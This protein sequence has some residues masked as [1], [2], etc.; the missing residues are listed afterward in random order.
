MQH[1]VR[2]SSEKHSPFSISTYGPRGLP[3]SLKP[4]RYE[5]STLSINDLDT[6]RVLTVSN[7]FRWLRCNTLRN[8]RYAFEAALRENPFQIYPFVKSRFGGRPPVCISHDR[9]REDRDK[10]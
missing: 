3:P 1:N 6:P 7:E 2:L 8:T 9:M 10:I 5:N 4:C